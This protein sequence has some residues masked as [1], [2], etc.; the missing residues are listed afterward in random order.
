[1][2]IANKIIWQ[3]AAGDKD[4]NYSELCLKWGVILNGPGS[5]T[6]PK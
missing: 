2:N 5:G 1:M 3:Q 4:C 6:P